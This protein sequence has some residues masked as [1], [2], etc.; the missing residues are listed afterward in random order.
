LG[1][2]TVRAQC[3]WHD[4]ERD[5]ALLKAV[6]VWM[7]TIGAMPQLMLLYLP[8]AILGFIYRSEL[9]R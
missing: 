8:A 7:I 9:E 6:I 4:E 5:P 2:I 3:A 1:I